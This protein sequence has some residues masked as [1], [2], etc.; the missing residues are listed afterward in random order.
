VHLSTPTVHLPA[1]HLPALRL[2]ARLS[3]A[4]VLL[5]V[6]YA[7]AIAVALSAPGQHAA[8]GSVVLAGLVGRWAVRRRR[9]AT[10]AVPVAAAAVDALLPDD[11]APATAPA[12]AA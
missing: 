7:V 3:T 4:A 10:A 6:V 2:P 1:V 9:T 12:T 11:G 5:S 8:A